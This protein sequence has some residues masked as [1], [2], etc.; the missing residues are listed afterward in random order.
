MIPRIDMTVADVNSSYDD[1]ITLL[2]ALC[3][4]VFLY[5]KMILTTL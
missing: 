5:M 1:I 2:R 4:H 3:I